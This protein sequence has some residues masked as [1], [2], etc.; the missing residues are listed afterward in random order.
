MCNCVALCLKQHLRVVGIN[1]SQRYTHV[2]INLNYIK[3]IKLTSESN[4]ITSSELM[5]I[6]IDILPF[7]ITEF[8]RTFIKSMNQE[9][10]TF[11]VNIFCNH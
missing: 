9:D 5:F 11:K 3:L 1:L 10:I 2:F 6:I 8:S 7:A 4:L